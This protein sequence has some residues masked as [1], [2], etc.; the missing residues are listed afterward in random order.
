MV[1]ARTPRK[2]PARPADAGA[3]APL[4]RAAPA[5]RAASPRRPVRAPADAAAPSVAAAPLAPPAPAEA[6]PHRDKLVRD[7]FTMPAS[8]Y[9]LIGQ[10]KHRAV[11]LARPAKKSELLR[12]GLKLLAAAADAALLAALQAT[13]TIK[14]G[15][16]KAGK[17]ADD[18]AVAGKGKKRDGKKD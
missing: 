8:E 7:S 1:S 17:P 6:K 3:K 14:T 11:A 10:L 15:R 16:P 2:T 13:P 18:A 9:A 12:A 4:K 5:K